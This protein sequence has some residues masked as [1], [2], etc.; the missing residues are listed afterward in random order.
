MV[1]EKA[2]KLCENDGA[3]FVGLFIYHFSPVLV[4]AFNRDPQVIAIGTAQAHTITLFYFL[5]AFSHCVAGI[6][7]GAGKST[8]PM[9]VMMV[10]WCIVRVT[11]ITIGIHFLPDIRIVFWAYPLTWSLSSL[12]F[13]VY[14]LRGKWVHGFEAADASA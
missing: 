14:F 7:R 12:V 6:L 4:A 2:H 13:L 5:L 11:Y 8:V 1:D 9:V 10:F 3:E